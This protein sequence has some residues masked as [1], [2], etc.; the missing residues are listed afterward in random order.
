MTRLEKLQERLKMIKFLLIVFPFLYGGIVL[1][2]KKLS[3]R[4]KII[5][6]VFS[7]FSIL[8]YGLLIKGCFDTKREISIIKSITLT[9][10]PARN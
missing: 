7:I 9:V 4:A 3:K 2:I 8:F 6:I 5:I 1:L 10:G